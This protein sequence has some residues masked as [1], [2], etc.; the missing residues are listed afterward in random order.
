MEVL[1]LVFREHTV[2]HLVD[3]LEFF[4]NLSFHREYHSPLF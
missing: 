2:H 4:V 3:V 1:V